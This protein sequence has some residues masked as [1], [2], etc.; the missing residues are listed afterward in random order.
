VSGVRELVAELEAKGAIKRLRPQLSFWLRLFVFHQL[1]T[2][3]YQVW[4]LAR[5]VQFISSER[6]FD[7][8][9][10][11]VALP[12]DVLR[13]MLYSAFLIAIVTGLVLVFR[14]SR[15][16][17]RY[18]VVALALVMPWRALEWLSF[19]LERSAL[20]RA[21]FAFRAEPELRV[22]AYTLASAM[23]IAWWGYWMRSTSVERLFG[24]RGFGGKSDSPV[25]A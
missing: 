14:R 22:W 2:V 15:N 18:W 25:S 19:R 16:A 24:T 10:R 12:F 13:F 21:G 11:K 17:P 8:T 5:I 6:N 7:E 3:A 1:F 9:F 20:E 4:S 23:I